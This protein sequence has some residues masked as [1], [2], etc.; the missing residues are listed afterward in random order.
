[1]KLSTIEVSKTSISNFARQRDKAAVGQLAE[2][3]R[4]VGLLNPITVVH[5]K[6]SESNGIV[7]D[8]GYRVVAGGHRLE[9]AK[10]LGWEHIEAFIMDCDEGDYPKQRMVEI[11]ENLHRAELTALERD[12]LVAE[13]CELVGGEGVQV[14][15]PDKRYQK[16]GEA[17]A[18]R[19]LGLSRPDVHRAL[20]V[21]SLSEPAQQKA[22]EL[23]LDDNRTA[24]LE[25][26]RAEVPEE[27]VR[28]LDERVERMH[29][30][31]E[32]ALGAQE[33]DKREGGMWMRKMLLLWKD[34][35]SDWQVEFLSKIKKG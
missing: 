10:L 31:R 13:W 5:A 35:R 3:M 7:R 14:E 30:M 18:S 9:A 27:Q 24:L 15:Q 1:M 2:S 12:K 26:A 28:R 17:E 11:A 29:K 25:A 16:R 23:G 8:G 32:D 21:A 6:Y 20:K 4:R 19:Q 33:R 22:R 34:G